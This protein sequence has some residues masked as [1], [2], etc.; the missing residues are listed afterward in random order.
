MNTYLHV[1]IEVSAL[2]YLTQQHSLPLNAGSQSCSTLLMSPSLIDVADRRVDVSSNFTSNH[3]FPPLV[4]R[5][6]PLLFLNREWGIHA[7][8]RGFPPIAGQSNPTDLRAAGCVALWLVF[9]RLH[10][11]RR[12]EVGPLEWAVAH[13]DLPEH[14]RCAGL[15]PRWQLIFSLPEDCHHHI[16]PFFPRSVCFRIAYNHIDEEVAALSLL[17]RIRLFDDAAHHI[18]YVAV[19]NAQSVVL[20]AI[21]G[22]S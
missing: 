4:K 6:H 20:S 3:H 22:P 18:D 7:V 9:I 12:L 21:L 1:G 15:E 10:L 11:K 5:F 19:G 14:D 2:R 16:F 8:K 17:W 13:S